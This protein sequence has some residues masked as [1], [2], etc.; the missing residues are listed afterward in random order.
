MSIEQTNN[1]FGM[2]M[3]IGDLS[4]RIK[5]L[6]ERSTQTASSNTDVISELRDEIRKNTEKFANV[7]DSLE[8]VVR[9]HRE[10]VDKKIETAREKL[11]READEKYVSKLDFAHLDK[12]LDGLT[13]K[14]TMIWSGIIIGTYIINWVV[15]HPGFL[16]VLT[17]IPK[18]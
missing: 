18:P 7:I 14:L 2:H 3:V 4:A 1:P 17:E 6:E 12:K 16:R 8:K 13:G 11:H 9:D 15:A 10:D 5:I